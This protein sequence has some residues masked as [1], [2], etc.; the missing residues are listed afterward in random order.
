M[1]FRICVSSEPVPIDSACVPSIFTSGK[2]VAQGLA[3]VKR[4]LRNVKKVNLI[5][6]QYVSENSVLQPNNDIC[7][8]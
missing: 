3:P 1:N 5:F 2:F 4:I 7:S 6:A 8:D